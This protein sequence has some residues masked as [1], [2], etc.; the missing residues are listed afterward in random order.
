MTPGSAAQI[1]VRKMVAT[2]I[3]EVMVIAA[4]LRDAP[5]WPQSA[6]L[7]ALDPILAPRRIASVAVNEQT[8][9]IVGFAVVS[10]QAPQAELESIAVRDEAHRQG[11]G[12]RLL[13]HLEDDLRAAAVN[14]IW[15]EVR[16]SNRAG[17]A[18]YLAHGWKQSGRRSRYYADPEEDAILMSRMI[19]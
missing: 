11:I 17:T 14:E 19:R 2:D 15:L 10:L 6:Y 18:F 16:A 3:E 4:G 8:C 1:A 12:S 7:A 5:H 9:R 13:A